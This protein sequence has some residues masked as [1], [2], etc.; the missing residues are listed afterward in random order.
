M[1]ISRLVRIIEALSLL[2]IREQKVALKSIL[3][4]EL[5]SKQLHKLVIGNQEEAR[6]FL[7]PLLLPNHLT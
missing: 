5:C 2:E 3:G 4:Q 7:R 1:T 6:E